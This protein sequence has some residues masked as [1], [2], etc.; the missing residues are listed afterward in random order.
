MY[1]K[2]IYIVQHRFPP[3][4]LLV[5]FHDLVMSHLDYSH[6]FLQNQLFPIA[7]PGKLMNWVLKSVFIC[8]TIKTS[9]ESRKKRL[10]QYTSLDYVQIS[11]FFLVEK[12]SWKYLRQHIDGIPVRIIVS[13]WVIFHLFQLRPHRCFIIL[14]WSGTHY[15][16]MSETQVWVYM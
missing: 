10:N 5:L 2:T 7:L 11:D 13:I 4:V 8:S 6:V 9:H 12:I 1:S 16:Y 3:G 14:H 15:Y